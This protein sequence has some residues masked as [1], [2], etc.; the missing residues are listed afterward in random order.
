M[1]TKLV[2]C[3]ICN[4]WRLK[5]DNDHCPICNSARLQIGNLKVY[6]NVSTNREV[7]RGIPSHTCNNQKRQL[8]MARI[9]AE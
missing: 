8:M 3:E 9:L 2:K 1:K 7:V 4:H 6:I 5:L